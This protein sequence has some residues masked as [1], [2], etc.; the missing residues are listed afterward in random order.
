MS[1]LTKLKEE[2]IPTKISMIINVFLYLLVS[3][4]S[5]F[6]AYKFFLEATAVGYA[7]LAVLVTIAFE[8]GQVASLFSLNTLGKSNKGLIWFLFLFLT[9]VQLISNIGYAYYHIDFT[10]DKYFNSLNE[11]FDFIP[12]FNTYSKRV[13][14]FLYSGSLPIIAVLFIKSLINYV[15][16]SDKSKAMENRESKPINKSEEK[17]DFLFGEKEP[18]KKEDTLIK[19]IPKEK[20]QP[21]KGK[22]VSKEKESVKKEVVSNEQ[23]IVVKKLPVDNTKE[24]LAK[25]NKKNTVRVKVI[26]SQDNHSFKDIDKSKLTI[27]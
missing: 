6:H 14:T 1:V 4:V 21:I 15:S 5:L 3:V 22:Q 25:S 18:V 16:P 19:E 12:N 17:V 9:F 8:L 10:F 26:N 23:K 11:F 2:S 7:I 13:F 24:S 27:F 20:D